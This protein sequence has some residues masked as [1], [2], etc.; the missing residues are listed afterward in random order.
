MICVSIAGIPLISF[1]FSHTK[2][3]AL[4]SALLALPKAFNR[5]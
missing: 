5:P 4:A 2:N 1:L 3:R